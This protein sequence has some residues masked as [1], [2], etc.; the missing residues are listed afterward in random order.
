VSRL[1]ALLAFVALSVVSNACEKVP[2][3]APSGSTITLTIGETSLPLNGTLPVTAVVIE[4]SGTAPQNGTVVTFTSSLGH[5]DP[6][7]A[8][9]QNGLARTTF[10][11][12]ARSGTATIRAFSGDAGA[13]EGSEASVDLLIGG[14]GVTTVVLRTEASSG[15]GTTTGIVATV[16]DG[17]G[18]PVPGVSVAFSSDRGQVIPGVATANGNGEARATLTTSEQTVVTA[19]VGDVSGTITIA[20]PGTLTLAVVSTPPFEVGQ[21]VNFTVT[22]SGT[23]FFSNVVVDFGDGRPPVSLG[24]VSGAR[25]F[26]YTFTQR[27]N[28]IVTA[29]GTTAS[30]PTSSSVGVQ[31]NDRAPLTVNLAG[32]TSAISLAATQGLVIFTATASLP[33]GT[34][35]PLARV[36]WSFGDGQTGQGTSLSINHRYSRTGTFLVTVRVVSTDGREGTASATVQVIP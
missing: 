20:A 25:N 19:S 1:I 6:I 14:A 22:P 8:R 17:D 5:F 21:P 24:A 11:A 12:G 23:S 3:L 35:A 34:A 15:A 18:N 4:G 30:G 16:L 26:T 10:H 33:G 9:T 7:E 27:G 29:T 32:P 31:V 2:L 13:G 36:D 28:F